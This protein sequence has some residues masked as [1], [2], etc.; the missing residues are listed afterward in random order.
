MGEGI[1]TENESGRREVLE[2]GSLTEQ[3]SRRKEVLR[4]Y[5]QLD[6][7]KKKLFESQSTK[8]VVKIRIGKIHFGYGFGPNIKTIQRGKTS[9]HKPK[10]HG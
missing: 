7:N 8:P 1:I 5:K 3:D 4:M 10:C 9:Q 2:E 6:V